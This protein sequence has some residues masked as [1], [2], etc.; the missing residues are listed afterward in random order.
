MANTITDKTLALAGIFQSAF[1]VQEVA[2]DGKADNEPFEASLRSILALDPPD[3]ASVY[4]GVDGVRLGL[5]LLV[6]ELGGSDQP[7]DKELV[8]YV[9]TVLHLE[10]QLAKQP[11]ML[12]KVAAGIQRAEGQSEHFSLTHENVIASL[13]GTY[14]DTISTLTPRIMVTGE[15]GYLSHPDVANK[16]RALLLAAIRSAVLW[17]QCGGGR[18]QLLFGRRA[19]L[20]EA[21]RLLAEGL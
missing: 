10:R 16:V 17:R 8:K 2:H 9:V 11:D 7:R 20:V 15:H 19:L 18:M 4:G 14:V 13:A 5:D 21:Q 12:Q 6:C 3:T 1:L